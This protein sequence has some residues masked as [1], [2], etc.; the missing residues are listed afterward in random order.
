MM[1]YQTINAA[2]ISLYSQ[3][4]SEDKLDIEAFWEAANLLFGAELLTAWAEAGGY[5]KI[6]EALQKNLR[7]FRDA[8]TT[9]RGFIKR[10]YQL[11]EADVFTDNSGENSLKIS[12]NPEGELDLGIT[13]DNLHDAAQKME[14]S[15][16]VLGRCLLVLVGSKTH[17]ME[18]IENEDG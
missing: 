6:F 12:V 15:P 4:Q 9:G 16:T 1:K 2:A 18:E 14:I 10:L 8:D 5:D 13:P 7:V 17:C 11:S 3:F